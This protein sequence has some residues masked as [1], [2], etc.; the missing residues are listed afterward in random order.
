[1]PAEAF[2]FDTYSI[3]FGRLFMARGVD[4]RPAKVLLFVRG[5]RP[6]PSNTVGNATEERSET[7]PRTDVASGERPDAAMCVR[8]VLDQ[9]VCNSQYFSQLA[10]FFI[11]P[12][13]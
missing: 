9:S 6:A 5:P 8:R 11:D 13:V 10:A 1:M 4:F 7:D 3:E 12:V 2:G